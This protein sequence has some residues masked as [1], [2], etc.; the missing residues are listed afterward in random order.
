LI[1]KLANDIEANIHPRKPGLLSYCWVVFYWRHDNFLN[2][3]QQQHTSEKRLIQMAAMVSETSISEVDGTT[4]ASG[5]EDFSDECP[6]KNTTSTDYDAKDV[7][8]S[9]VVG[10]VLDE[11]AFCLLDGVFTTDDGTHERIKIPIPCLPAILGRTRLRSD[12]E[13]ENF[14]PMGTAKTLS[15][16]NFRIDYR[17]L[18][19]TFN[20]EA[21][22]KFSFVE[23]EEAYNSITKDPTD[24]AFF[25]ITCIGK[26]SMLVDGKNIKQGESA[27]ISHGSKVVIKK[28]VLQFCLPKEGTKVETT[29]VSNEVNRSVLAVKR[30]QSIGSDTASAVTAV[31]GKKTKKDTAAG[32]TRQAELDDLSTEDLL[33]QFFANIAN[34][35]WDRRQSM[36]GGTIAFRAIVEAAYAKELQHQ[37]YYER[38]L[39]RTVIMDW[40][41]NS[42][43]FS[44]WKKHML[45]N[46]EEKSYQAN[47]TKAMM[48]AGYERT[49]SAGRYVKW[50]LPVEIMKDYIPRYDDSKDGADS[51]TDAPGENDDDDDGDT[52]NDNDSLAESDEMSD[53]DERDNSRVDA[54][55]DSP[56][57][58][59]VEV[60]LRSPDKS[61][62]AESASIIKTPISDKTK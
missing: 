40:V 2:Q 27:L 20:Y 14:V 7:I 37:A 28:F 4:V 32:G 13:S 8:N 54:P 60:S 18:M 59:S 52:N 48:K 46:L 33:Q 30:R 44:E 61:V 31:K 22:G 29:T 43:K 38:G 42:D 10:G 9:N 15:R 6:P 35:E 11:P 25:A 47:I 23:N 5:M 39:F 56:E 51:V 1:N 62:D 53:G 21:S 41:A 49:S 36:I 55:V 19:G 58:K 57:S 3:Q 26:N 12:G 50:T 17:T 34:G 24:T 45:A 16:Q